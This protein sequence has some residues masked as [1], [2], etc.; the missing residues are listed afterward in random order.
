M[1]QPVVAQ[2]EAVIFQQPGV[3]ALQRLAPLAQ[4]GAVRL[5][6]VVDAGLVTVLGAQV[7]AGLGVAAP[8]GKRRPD[9]DHDRVRYPEQALEHQGVADVRRRAAQATDS[10]LPLTSMSL[11]G[12][13]TLPMRVKQPSAAAV[14]LLIR[15]RP[16]PSA[17]THTTPPA[18]DPRIQPPA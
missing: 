13:P 7:A 15:Q 14:W 10:P 5:S 2:A 17:R 1:A 3:G 11:S 6:P 16:L 9:P 8:V 12:R 4:A 18:R